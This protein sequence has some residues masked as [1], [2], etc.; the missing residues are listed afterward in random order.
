M[1]GLYLEHL[2]RRGLNAWHQMCWAECKLLHLSE[3]VGRV[4]VQNHPAHLNQRVLRLWPHLQEVSEENISDTSE[5]M[6][7]GKELPCTDISSNNNH[8]MAYI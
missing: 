1:H 6:D 3:V 5:D 7:I 4:V 8:C 2:V